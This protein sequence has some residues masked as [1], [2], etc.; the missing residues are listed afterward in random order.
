MSF[1][2]LSIDDCLV[3]EFPSYE[4]LR[5]DFIHPSRMLD[6]ICEDHELRDITLSVAVKKR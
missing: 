1:V 3:L 4:L 6:D 2:S 5:C